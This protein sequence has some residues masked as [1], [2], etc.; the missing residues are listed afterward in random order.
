MEIRRCRR[1]SHFIV[2]TGKTDQGQKIL[3]LHQNVA[4]WCTELKKDQSIHTFQ[5]PEQDKVFKVQNT[6]EK[7]PIH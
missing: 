6:N 7:S 4:A 3:N 5:K 1:K 2:F